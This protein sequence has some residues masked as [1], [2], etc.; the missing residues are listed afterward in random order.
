MGIFSHWY[1]LL[2]ILLLVLIVYGP[3]KLPEVGAAI[4][5]AMREFRKATTDITD[6]I[7]K[8]TSEPVADARPA[9]DPPVSDLKSPTDTKAS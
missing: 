2:A 1:F 8:S 4:G 3:G 7:K 6:D 5:K 9:P